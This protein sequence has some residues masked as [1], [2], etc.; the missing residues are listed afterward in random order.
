MTTLCSTASLSRDEPMAG[1]A[2]RVD[3]WLLVEHPGP[4]GPPSL[5]LAR[6]DPQVGAHLAAAAAAMGARLLLLRRPHHPRPEEIPPR[7]SAEPHGRQVFLADSR[8][9]LERLLT[10]YVED[11][12][13]LLAL[14]L[15]E[16]ALSSL[17]REDRSGWDVVDEPLLLVCTH[18][19]H[20]RCCA[21]RGRPVA[22]ALAAL[23]PAPVWEC[24]HTGGDR[25]AANV[26]VLPYGLYLGRVAAT[27]AGVLLAD[28]DGRR[29]P[30]AFLRG[31]SSLTLPAQAAQLFARVAYGRDGLDD[32]LPSG[33]RETAADTW[34]VRLGGPG[35]EVEV[36][37]RYDRA[38]DGGRHVLTCDAVEPR[39]APVFRQVSMTRTGEVP[40]H[41]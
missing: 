21:I 5:P 1:T 19:R 23:R 41:R 36:V 14:T 10:R 13:A 32:L 7:S 28:L 37:V 33:Q 3:R 27:D 38:G 25:F 20:D 24:S 4:W 29:V 30:G 39:S 17:H 35:G 12:P 26:L 34:A 18:G 6:M 11:D 8:P 40:Q 31:R 15:N 9:G 22:A 2:S 16:G